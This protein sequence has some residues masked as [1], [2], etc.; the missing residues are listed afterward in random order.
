MPAAAGPA[1]DRLPPRPD[2]PAELR[3]LARHD[4]RIK[5]RC[6]PLRDLAVACKPE[7]ATLMAAFMPGDRITIGPPTL[8]LGDAYAVR[9]TL[10]WFDA[11][12]MDPPYVIR[13]SGLP[14]E[15]ITWDNGTEFHD[16][17][18]IE[19]VSTSHRTED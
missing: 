2:D 15:T 5:S 3:A 18:E 11:D 7:G 10:G 1:S 6:S 13:T 19:E 8:I 9:P 14:F 4:A 12:V 17:R 16:Y